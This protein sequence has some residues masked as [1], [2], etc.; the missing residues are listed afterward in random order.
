MEVSR[1]FAMERVHASRFFLFVDTGGVRRNPN[2]AQAAEASD[3]I[4]NQ[5]NLHSAGMGL[6][7]DFTPTTL[8][9]LTLASPLGTN[10]AQVN[11]LNADGRGLS[12]SRVWFSLNSRY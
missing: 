7:L 5:Y 3:G 12:Q 1:P 9:Q 11:G 8:M 2:A 4:R 10:P 6:K